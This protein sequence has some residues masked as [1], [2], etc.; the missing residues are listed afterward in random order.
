MSTPV[1]SA[2]FLI[3]AIL[4]SLAAG[5]PSGPE[6]VIER[7]PPP[8]ES[9]IAPDVLEQRMA[10]MQ[11]QIDELSAD[12]K[13]SSE[14]AKKKA[15]QEAK[16]PSSRLIMQLQAD[17]YFFDQDAAS[18]AALGDIQDGSAFRRARVGW[19]GEH[20]VT[21]YRIEVDFAL[22][23]RPS[24]LDVWAGLKDVGPAALLRVGHYFEPFSLERLTAN[25]FVTFMERSLPDQAFAPAR[26]LGLMANGTLCEEHATWAIGMFRTNSDDFS[27]DVGDNGERAV[28]G[29]LTWLAWHDAQDAGRGYVHLGAGYSFRD[30]D[31]DAVRF[32]SQPEARVGAAAPNVPF[33][34]DTGVLPASSYQLYGLEAALVLGAFSWQAE[35]IYTP[36]NR[37]NADDASFQAAYTTVSYFLTGEHRPYKRGSGTFD[38]VLPLRP[39]ARDKDAWCSLTGS[40][41]W[42][43]A[44]RLSYLDL[45]DAGVPGGELTDATLGLNWYATPYLRVTT[46]WVHAFLDR[47]TSSDTDIFGMR[48]GYDY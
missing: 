25:R 34:V 42:E 46:N 10:A 11:K 12:A 32:R 37:I 27:D 20:D 3:L 5:Q 45:N 38:R 43:I 48:V 41:A 18:R 47:T 8:A 36:V 1:L 26:N 29:R 14:A 2:A 19:C 7:L 35:Y 16:K 23:G 30:A 21:E 44:A 31:N 15:E 17:T 4:S 39:L 6:F 28:T 33:F 9:T 22:P 13:K 40:G 24:F